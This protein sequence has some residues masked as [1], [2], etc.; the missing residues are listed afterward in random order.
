VHAL[1]NGELKQGIFITLGALHF[2]VFMHH[3]ILVFTSSFGG[4]KYLTSMVK[5]SIFAA[6]PSS[7][8]LLSSVSNEL[9]GCML[10]PAQSQ[11]RHAQAYDVV[12][13]I[14]TCVCHK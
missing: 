9:C 11:T 6:W 2:S 1:S 13:S 5:A 12:A 3:H 14:F 8:R 10:Q 7:S 4:Q